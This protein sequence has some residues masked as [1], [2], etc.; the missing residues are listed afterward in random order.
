MTYKHP[1]YKLACALNKVALHHNAEILWH[2]VRIEQIKARTIEV[3]LYAINIYTIYKTKV[4]TRTYIYFP[5][6][7]YIYVCVIPIRGDATVAETVR[8]IRQPVCS[9]P[10]PIRVN[11]LPRQPVRPVGRARAAAVSPIPF[12]TPPISFSRFRSIET[13]ARVTGGDP[14]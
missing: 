6:I 5:H 14:Q 9:R 12:P 4:D 11:P 1:R 7:R 2:T 13:H 8:P 3:L 10:R